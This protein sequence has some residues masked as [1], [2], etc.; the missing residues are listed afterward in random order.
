VETRGPP[1]S[2]TALASA[3]L[4]P[5]QGATRAAYGHDLRAWLSWCENHDVDPLAARRAHVDAYART[6]AEV[7]GRAPATVSRH[8]SS[9]AG[10]YKDAVAQD[11]IARNPV[12]N[13]Q[14]P[15]V[16]TDNVSTGLDRDELAALMAAGREE[17]PRSFALVLLLGVNVLRISEA[18]GAD[19]EDL[20][21]EHGHRVLEVTAGR[22]DGHHPAGATYGRRRR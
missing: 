1:T 22:E 11:L 3:F 13:V 21:T 20:G 6:L 4:L 8:L 15:K 18:L 9:L 10:F 19:I 7:D 2:I 12:A 16:G 17:S 5:C 14:R